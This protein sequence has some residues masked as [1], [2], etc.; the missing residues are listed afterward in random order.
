ML[1]TISII[2]S[3]EVQGVFYRQ[4]TKEN[5]TALGITGTVHNRPDSTVEIIAT[6]EEEQLSQ[7]FDWCKK[8]PPSAIVTR[9]EKQDLPL[10]VFNKFSI[11]R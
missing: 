6:G 5:A 2:V 11:V 7:F 10:Q 9:I 1:Q 3:G 8:G 4:S